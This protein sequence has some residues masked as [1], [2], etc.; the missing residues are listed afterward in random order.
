MHCVNIMLEIK[1][2]C[3]LGFIKWLAW[4][5]G[6]SGGK[7][8]KINLL[9]SIPLGRPDTQAI[10]WLVNWLVDWL[11]DWLNWD[12]MTDQTNGWRDAEFD[13][14]YTFLKVRSELEKVYCGIDVSLLVSVWDFRV[15]TM[16]I[17][18]VSCM[19]DVIWIK[20]KRKTSVLWHG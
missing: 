20:R 15:F 16:I 7:K 3:V 19:L 4:V 14:K 1:A 5:S 9:S 2:C 6:V 13:M 8:G 11:T 18:N 17:S 12:K 10:K